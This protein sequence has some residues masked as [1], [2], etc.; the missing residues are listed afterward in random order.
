MLAVAQGIVNSHPTVVHRV[1]FEFFERK[2]STFNAKFFLTKTVD[3]KL[4]SGW[5]DQ[6]RPIKAREHWCGRVSNYFSQAVQKAH[7]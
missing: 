4:K 6:N 5:N 1:N 7:D 2:K 3:R